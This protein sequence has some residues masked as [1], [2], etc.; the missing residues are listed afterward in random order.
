MGFSEEF[1]KIINQ[2]KYEHVKYTKTICYDA[3]YY[4]FRWCFYEQ[5]NHRRE[6]KNSLSNV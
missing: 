6:G 4:N 2:K 1:L 5:K 3:I